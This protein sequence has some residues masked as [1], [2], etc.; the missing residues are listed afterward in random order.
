VNR[1]NCLTFTLFSSRDLPTVFRAVSQGTSMV[2]RRH[3]SNLFGGEFMT[4]GCVHLGGV[5]LAAYGLTWPAR[6][7]PPPDW[8][9]G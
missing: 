3:S 5:W 9:D 1:W 6:M 4:T 7:L 8:L 2:R